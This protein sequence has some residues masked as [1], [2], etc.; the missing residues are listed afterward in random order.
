M[1]G[2]VTFT[3]SEFFSDGSLREAFEA[4]GYP[5][6]W[7]PGKVRTIPRALAQRVKN[8]GGELTIPEEGD[9]E[10]RVITKSL[11]V[12]VDSEQ[13][14]AHYQKQFKRKRLRVMCQNTYG[15]IDG[16]LADALEA[17]DRYPQIGFGEILEVP[18]ALLPRLEASGFE[19]TD[20]PEEM[21]QYEGHYQARYEHP[22]QAWREERAARRAQEAAKQATLERHAELLAQIDELDGLFFQAQR[23][24]DK[25][26]MASYTNQLRKLWAEVV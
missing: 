9:V 14:V 23:K 15:F 20:N 1:D 18:P 10:D 21:A 16:N 12:L 6:E 11:P 25:A 3:V 22:L 8:S 17:I 24:G 13:A 5:C 19:W 7:K 26:G 4:L 2:M